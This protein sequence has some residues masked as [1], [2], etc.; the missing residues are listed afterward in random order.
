M[1]VCVCVCLYSCLC[2]PEPKAHL[3][4]K[5]LYCHI[6]GVWLYYILPHLINGTIFI[7][8]CIDHKECA[9]IFSTH[10]STTFLIL[11]RIQWL[12]IINVERSSCKVPPFLSDFNETRILT[13][14]HFKKSSNIKS[15]QWELSCSMWM[16]GQSGR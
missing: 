16:D 2:Y 6:W 4:Y 7:K 15:D 11:R 10:F 3:F 13:D 1:C 14:F 9:L 8:K 5:E 12:I